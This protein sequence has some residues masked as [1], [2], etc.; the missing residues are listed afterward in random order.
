MAK[1]QSIRHA[2]DELP[3]S[4][5]T[6]Y[7]LQALDFVVPGQWKN[8]VGFE[9]MLREVSGETDLARLWAI[10]EKSLEIYQNSSTGY[11]RA[12]WIYQI[13]DK[14]DAALGTVALAS[15]IG[16]KV[17]LLSFLNRL[18]PSPSMAQSIDL[19]LK[20]MAEL[21]AFCQINGLPKDVTS[22]KKF[23]SALT[24]YKQESPMRMAALVCFDGVIPLGSDFV[25]KAS[26]T[27]G[28]LKPSD[29]GNNPMFRSVGELIPGSGSKGQLHFINESFE[30]VKG[31]MDNF[32]KKGGVTTDKITGHLKQFIEF[33]DDKLPYLAAFLDMATNERLNIQGN[34]QNGWVWATNQYGQGGWVPANRLRFN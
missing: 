25:Q 7:T 3:S 21:V 17:N 10:S 30:S 28:N 32:L 11:Q 6:V 31:W 1:I 14:A 13:V 18:T 12:L 34:E 33:S 9:T 27:L 5:L 8:S 20:V 26:L 19:G 24:D 2:V 4:G 22:I 29:L 15:K 16:G 23:S